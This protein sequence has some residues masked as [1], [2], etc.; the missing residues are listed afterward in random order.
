MKPRLFIQLGRTGDL[1]NLLP[2]WWRLHQQ[3][4]QRPR[5][6]TRQDYLPLLAGASYVEA[7]PFDGRIDDPGA[8]LAWAKKNYPSHEILVSQ[9]ENNPVDNRRVTPCYQMESW[10]LAGALDEF[11]KWPLVLE[12]M[13]DAPAR[14]YENTVLVC[15]NSISSP[16][17]HGSALHAALLNSIPNVRF[18]E[19]GGERFSSPQVWI[20]FFNVA[21]CL[22]T[23]DTMHLHLSRA[24]RVPVVAI[25]Q[26]RP[27]LGSV[28]PP[29]TVAKFGYAEAGHDLAAVVA[30]VRRVLATKCGGTAVHAVHLHGKTERHARAQ[31]TWGSGLF[32]RRTS[33]ETLP[34]TAQNIGDPRPLPYL[35]DILAHS[36]TGCHDSDLILWTNDDVALL[37]GLT[38]WLR[39]HVALYGAA[40]MRR[41]DAHIGRDLFAFTAKWL[42]DNWEELPDYIIG[43]CDWDLG[44]AAMIRA[45]RGIVTCLGN[46]GI[47]FYPCDATERLYTHEEH[48]SEWNVADVAN[49]PSVRHNRECFRKWAEKYCPGIRFHRDGLLA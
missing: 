14:P 18:I 20:P 28:P 32:P 7:I 9:Y 4:G 42:R 22:V 40:S 25:L 31:A 33:V 49:V 12:T 3:T 37:P 2:L 38:D 46:V 8:A 39:S 41:S 43:T 30:A 35:K 13:K 27:H 21:R 47:D 24:A 36:M 34:R 6:V 26:D 48:P 11:G 44:L 29:A 45:K 15:T 10:R 5:I 16:W 19:I 17:P 1:I 23:V